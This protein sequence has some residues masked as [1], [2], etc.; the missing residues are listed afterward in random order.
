MSDW[1]S[2]SSLVSKC[3]SC[4]ANIIWMKS[5]SGKNVPVDADSVPDNITKLIFNPTTM[6]AHFATCP[7]AEKFRK[8]KKAQSNDQ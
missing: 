1:R 2:E 3:R 8:V 6:I 5:L 4:K 7:D